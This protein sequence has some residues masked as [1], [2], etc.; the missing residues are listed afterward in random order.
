MIEAAKKTHKNG[1]GG[2]LNWQWLPPLQTNGNVEC[3]KVDQIIIELNITAPIVHLDNKLSWPQNHIAIH[4]LARTPRARLFSWKNFNLA[5]FWTD[6]PTHLSRS[7]FT[8]SFLPS[9]TS[10]ESDSQDAFKAGPNS[11][12]ALLMER[13]RNDPRNVLRTGHFRSL[14]LRRFST[15]KIRV[16]N[17]PKN[18]LRTGHFRSRFLRHFST[19]K[20]RV[21]SVLTS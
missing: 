17:H 4:L 21:R 10:S 15:L 18:V 5:D 3:T 14:F 6:P 12:F 1:Q 8:R 16:R 19:L 9:S 13:V 11:V 7:E 20:I 2:Q